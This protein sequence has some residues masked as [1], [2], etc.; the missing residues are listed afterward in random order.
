MCSTADGLGADAAVPPVLGA[1]GE[2]QLI[3][4]EGSSSDCFPCALCALEP[5]QQQ[6]L[7]N[8]TVLV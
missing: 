2:L 8:A 7:H 5:R 1:R 4:R 3:L 6:P